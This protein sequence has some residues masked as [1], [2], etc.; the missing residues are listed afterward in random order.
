M[1]RAVLLLFIFIFLYPGGYIHAKEIGPGVVINTKNYQ[2][3]LPELK[4]LLV[5][6]S[7]SVIN[8]LQNGWISLAI[9]EKGILKALPSFDKWSAKNKGKCRIEPGN[10]LVGWKA[11]L[12]FLHPKNGSEL[13]VNIERSHQNCEQY[14]IHFK[15]LLFNKNTQLERSFKLHLYGR[16]WMG[17]TEL[18][19]IPEEHGNNGTIRFKES[20][21]VYEPFDV[22]GFTQVRIRYDD[23]KKD[24][25]SYS[26]IPAIR[27]LR[28][29]TGA[30]VTDP[31]LGSD[32]ANDDFECLRQKIN[33]RM[34]FNLLPSQKFMVPDFPSNKLIYSPLTENCAQVNW[35]I[36]PL[37]ILT[38][39]PNDPDYCYKKRV[40]YV[41]PE[42]GM[43]SLWGSENYDQR[44][45]F[46][47]STSQIVHARNPETLI[48]AKPWYNALVFDH[49]S[50]HSTMLDMVPVC[51]DPGIGYDKFTIRNLLRMAR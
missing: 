35:Q 27:R 15:Y 31:I 42:G 20:I 30:D 19:P 44:G 39:Y 16:F 34:T 47:R 11:G 14:Y 45:R 1:K 28:R 7:F 48:T 29:L 25:E 21:I 13:A 9:V 2:T 18:P 5:P 6:N 3:Y 37:L 24:D 33:S 43:A 41:D 51:P 23:V 26:Y 40:L 4:R 10:K 46:W 32:L 50:G 36:R 38:I 22:K 12:P 17:R 49:L 8:G